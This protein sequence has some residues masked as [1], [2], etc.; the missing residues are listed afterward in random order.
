MTITERVLEILT[1]EGRYRALPNP[2]K[3]GSQEFTF[4]Q[5][6]VAS[7]KGND[8][9][10]VIELTSITD[11]SS[12][13]RSVLAFTRALDVLRS[14]RSVTTVLTSGQADK[15]LI[16]AINKVCRVLPIGAPSY[17]EIDT[18]RDWLA[19]LLP[20]T[21]PPRV[22]HLADWRTNLNK[23]LQEG[24]ERLQMDRFIQLAEDGQEAVEQALA[25]A[26]AELADDALNEGRPET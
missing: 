23:S 12:V 21:S 9:V 14:R 8:L 25:T 6:L 20:L 13:I 10:I 2:V 11:N 7:D 26:I 15:D 19:V 16:N 17:D 18:I 22:E 4:T 5:V 24:P 1:V 3:I